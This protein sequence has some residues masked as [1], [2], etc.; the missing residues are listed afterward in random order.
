MCR[1]IPVGASGVWTFESFSL[2]LGRFAIVVDR[3]TVGALGSPLMRTCAGV[4]T[5][6]GISQEVRP[7]RTART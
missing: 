5:C 2:D 7:D 6:S 3:I 1:H 4:K